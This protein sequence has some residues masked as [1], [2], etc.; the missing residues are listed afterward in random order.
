VRSDG[1]G[2][3][4]QAWNRSRVM[5][6]FTPTASVHVDPAA[7]LVGRRDCLWNAGR[8]N[9]TS[10]DEASRLTDLGRR[11]RTMSMM[12]SRGNSFLRLKP[13]SCLF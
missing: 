10:E 13:R 3:T 8:V 7:V 6:I 12:A 11:S 4:L 9:V 2:R 5:A 1:A